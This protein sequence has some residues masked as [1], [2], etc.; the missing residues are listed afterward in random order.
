MITLAHALEEGPRKLPV[1]LV[2]PGSFLTLHYRLDV[3]KR[4]ALFNTADWMRNR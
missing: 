1:T 2:Q 3:Y 4:Q